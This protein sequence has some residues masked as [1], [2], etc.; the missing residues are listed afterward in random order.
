[1]LRASGQPMTSVA[2]NG[3]GALAVPISQPLLAEPLRLQRI[4]AMRQLWIGRAH[5]GDQRVHH[6]ALDAIAQMPRI[7]DVL[8]PTPIVGDVLVLGERVGDQR[9]GA[10][11]GLEGLCQR[12]GR[13]LALCAVTVLQ[14]IER[15][16]D[17]ELFGAD[18]E[19]QA[20]DGL[21]E[22]P[23]EGGIAGLRLLEE[24]LLELVVELVRLLLAQI[25]DPRTVIRE[26]RRPASRG[27]KYRH[28]R[29]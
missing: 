29:G 5:R 13:S 2:A 7:R 20:G 15:R 21:V 14:E 3:S 9:K 27:S 28:R 6:L 8:E 4:I 19:A 18:L 17:R 10:L 1:M 23:V 26:A 16:L 22:Q 11:I 25:L 24:E 12:F